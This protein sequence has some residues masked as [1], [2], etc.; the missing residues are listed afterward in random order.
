M[1]VTAQVGKVNTRAVAME[2]EHKTQTAAH[3]AMQAKLQASEP[4]S[5]TLQGEGRSMSFTCDDGQCSFTAKRMRPFA[6]SV[7]VRCIRSGRSCIR[8]RGKNPG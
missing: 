2:S 5:D 1:Q 8:M 7:T 6:M 4:L 3:Q